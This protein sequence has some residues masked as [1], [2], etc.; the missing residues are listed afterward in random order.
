MPAAC[1]CAAVLAHPLHLGQHLG[2]IAGGWAG[3]I[4]ATV[5]RLGRGAAQHILL[6]VPRIDHESDGPMQAF[7]SG[8]G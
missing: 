6:P 4:M 3:A 7:S 5:S 1:C 8:R 2:W